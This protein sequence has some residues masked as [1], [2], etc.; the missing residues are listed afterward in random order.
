MLYDDGNW[1]QAKD[2]LLSEAADVN[3]QAALQ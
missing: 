2:L 3:A 1:R